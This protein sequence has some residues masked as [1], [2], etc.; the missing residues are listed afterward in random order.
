MSGFCQDLRTIRESFKFIFYTCI[1]RAHALIETHGNGSIRS[2]TSK[3]P[4]NGE[5]SEQFKVTS[6]EQTSQIQSNKWCSST[7]TSRYATYSKK[8]QCTCT[9]KCWVLMY[10]HR[11]WCIYI[12]GQSH[13]S[14]RWITV[15]SRIEDTRQNADTLTRERTKA[16]WGIGS[17]A[18]ADEENSR[19]PKENWVWTRT[20]FKYPHKP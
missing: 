9:Y 7:Q 14:I 16:S 5:R 4:L 13:K 1:N 15:D 10:A 3:L 2:L 12:C 17:N 6:V 11:T 18:N 8:S 20:G 19:R